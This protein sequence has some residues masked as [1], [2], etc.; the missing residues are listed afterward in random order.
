MKMYIFSHLHLNFAKSA[1][2]AQ[3]NCREK[4]QYAYQ[5]NA[6]FYTDIKFVDAGFQ[7]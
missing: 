6:E 7:K 1:I 3:K 4:Y 2:M 5:K